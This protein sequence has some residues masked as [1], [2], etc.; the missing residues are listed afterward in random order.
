MFLSARRAEERALVRYRRYIS[1]I[2]KPLTAVRLSGEIL[3]GGGVIARARF[4]AN[5]RADDGSARAA[6]VGILGL[7]HSFTAKW[8]DFVYI[9]GIHHRAEQHLLNSAERIDIV[10]AEAERFYAVWRDGYDLVG[11]IFTLAHRR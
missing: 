8:A 4:G 7:S 6:F 9:V 3:D 2:V 11:I 1:V 10:E 5:V